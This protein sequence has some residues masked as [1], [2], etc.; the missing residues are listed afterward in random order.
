MKIWHRGKLAA[1]HGDFLQKQAIRIKPI[2]RKTNPDQPSLYEFIIDESDPAWPE[3]KRRLGDG[4][5]YILTEFTQDEIAKAE[6][7]IA[8]ASH[9][10]GSFVPEEKW[11]CDLYYGDRC[12]NCGSGWRQIA[13]FRIKKEPRLGKNAF[14]DFGSA[15]ELF[16][17]LAVVEAFKKHGMVGFETRPLVLNKENS[18]L[19]SIRQLVVTEVA[20]P[21][22][23]EDLVE[24]EHYSQTDCPVCGKTWH[25]HYTRGALP[26]KRSALNQNV[27]FQLTNE[28]FGNGRTARREILFSRRVVHLALENSWQGIQFT[29]V[30][31]E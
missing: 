15:F 20:Q 23:A 18:P 31:A 10:I 3:V 11:W 19:E 25:T 8:S 24:R 9:S 1:E 7:S 13:P 16:C 30:N 5:T 4:H 12:K 21:A 27:D 29:P 14:A 22:I 28:W 17:T 6:W 2:F 26:L